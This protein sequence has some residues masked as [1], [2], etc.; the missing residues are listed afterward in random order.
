MDERK[1]VIRLSS[2]IQELRDTRKRTPEDSTE[3][4]IVKDLSSL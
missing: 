3:P 1:Q 2:F 4:Q